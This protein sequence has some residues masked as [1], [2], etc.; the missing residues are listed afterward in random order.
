MNYNNLNAI[1]NFEQQFPFNNKM[2]QKYKKV[3]PNPP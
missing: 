1:H 2:Q 3:H